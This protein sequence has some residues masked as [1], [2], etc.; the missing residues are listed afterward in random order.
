VTYPTFGEVAH[1]LIKHRPPATPEVGD[2]LDHVRWAFDQLVEQLDDMVP[3]GSDAT[4]AARSIHRA[5]QD[6]IFAVVHNQV[7]V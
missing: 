3:A 7:E 1:D 6:V 4:L 5:C 2:M